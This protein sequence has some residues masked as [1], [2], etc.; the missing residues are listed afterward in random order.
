MK[1][2]SVA[3]ALLCGAGLAVLA[4][5]AYAYTVSGPVTRGCHE[6][7]ASQAL[8][9]ARAELATAAPLPATEDDQALIDD[10]EFQA[11][12]DMRDIGAASMLIGDRDN[13]LK[14]HGSDD[15]SQLAEV[16]GDPSTQQEHC[17]RGPDDKEP[18][19]S[20]ATIARCR[21]FIKQRVRDSLA[22][23]DASGRPDITK[24]T[25]IHVTLDLRGGVDVPLPTYYV[26]IGQALHAI[27]D[28]FAHSYRTPDQTK[29]TVSLDW[30]DLANGDLVESRDGPA[31]TVELDRC[32]DA[33]TLRTVRH[34]L[35]VAASASV[36]R[37]TLDPESTTDQKLS[38]TDAVLDKYVSYSPGCTYD[39]SWCDAPERQY[40]NHGCL[41]STARGRAHARWPAGAGVALV[42]LYLARHGRLRRLHVTA[43]A[44]LLGGAAVL[45]TSTARAQSPNPGE[46]TAAPAQ[47]DTTATTPAPTKPSPWASWGAFAGGS[48]SVDH[49][50]LAGALGLRYRASRHWI[51]GLDGEWNPWV[52]KNGSLLH[53][54]T[55]ALY[56]TVIFQIPLANADASLRSSLSLG[57]STLLFN[58]FGAPKGSTGLYADINFLG[59]A[60]RVSRR[61]LLIVNP[62]NIA[63]PAP[64][65]EALPLT[66]PQYRF[67]IGLEGYL[68]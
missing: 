44:A 52:T 7:I 49:P 65:L 10:L 17:L 12:G 35:A 14:G 43:G 42:L 34:G 11:D 47:P 62:V 6:S 16:Q 27:Q 56:G 53:A 8:R 29:P 59:V 21:A 60:W 30:L 41:C 13:D 2:S 5:T 23:L 38:A 33:D 64:Q 39:N 22:G 54:G 20:A 36:L 45:A 19:G 48:A 4:E 25:T 37:A 66:Y 46:T 32:D 28:S 51:F 26:R 18:G 15:L 24:R 50:A 67:T 31:H 40:Q 58:L 63:I 3:V 9:A 57:G 1:L 68:G 55:A 61:L